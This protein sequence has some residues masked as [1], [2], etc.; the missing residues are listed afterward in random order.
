LRRISLFSRRA[1]L[2]ASSS[3]SCQCT[4]EVACDRMY[5]LLLAEARL[6]SSVLLCLSSRPDMLT[7]SVNC[8]CVCC[9]WELCSLAARCSAAPRLRFDTDGAAVPA[10]EGE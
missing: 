7:S 8:D 1:R 9:D 10:G 3:R 2:T 4:G 5:G 6:R